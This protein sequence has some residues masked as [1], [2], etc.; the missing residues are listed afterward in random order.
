MFVRWSCNSSNCLK[1]RTWEIIFSAMSVYFRMSRCNNVKRF[2]RFGLTVQTCRLS[3]NA[4]CKIHKIYIERLEN[5]FPNIVH[6][7]SIAV[8]NYIFKYTP[9]KQN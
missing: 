4:I 8:G 1:K 5:V 7:S 6:K 9:I 2:L 3:E